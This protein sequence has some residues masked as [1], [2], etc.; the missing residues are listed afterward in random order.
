MYYADASEFL[1]K[2]LRGAISPAGSGSF[3]YLLSRGSRKPRLNT[4]FGARL[5]AKR[6]PW[7]VLWAFGVERDGVVSRYCVIWRRA[8]QGPGRS[9][10]FAVRAAAALLGCL[11][12]S[13][14]CPNRDL[15]NT[16]CSSKYTSMA[17]EE[18]CSH[19]SMHAICV[20]YLRPTK[21]CIVGSFLV[22]V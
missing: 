6:Y 18:G 14:Y 7:H 13:R 5:C 19:P 21:L 20:L 3:S 17:L 9:K 15:C 22:F 8:A 12:S 2:C 10:Y 4:M 1:R 11:E 16:Y